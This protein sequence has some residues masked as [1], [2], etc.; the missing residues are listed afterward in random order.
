V[1]LAKDFAEHGASA[2]SVLT[3]GAFFRGT[4]IIWKRF[5]AQ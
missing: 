4:C 5:T 1:A 3:E 2:V